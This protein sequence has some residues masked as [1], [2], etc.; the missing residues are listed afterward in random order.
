MDKL[1]GNFPEI[2]LK[3]RKWPIHQKCDS[4]IDLK[5]TTTTKKKKKKKK[6]D[7]IKA[8][9]ISEVKFTTQHPPHLMTTLKMHNKLVNQNLSHFFF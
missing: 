7:M 8:K 5:A 4:S 9:L 2:A 1:T 6:K 3:R